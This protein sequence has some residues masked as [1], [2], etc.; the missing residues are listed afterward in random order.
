M[1]KLLQ[2]LIALSLLTCWLQVGCDGKTATK[3]EERPNVLL[4]TID[5]LRADRLPLYGYEK[6]KTPHL[7]ALASQGVVFDKA[8]AHTPITLPS[9]TSILTG[10]YPPQHGVR[11]N[12]GFYVHENLTTMAEILKTSRYQTAAFVSAFVLDSRFGLDQGFDLYDDDLVDGRRRFS[13]FGVKDRRAE[14]TVS[15]VI[16]WLDKKKDVKSPFFVW[17]HLY[18]PHFKY[19]P[20]EPFLSRFKDPYDGEIAYTD[21]EIGRL[22]DNLKK[23]GLYDNTLVI[24]T[25]D[26]GESFGEHGE[27]THS[28]FVYEATQW[29]PM[30]IKFPYSAHGGRRIKGLVR[31]I[32]ILPTALETLGVNNISKEVQGSLPGISLLSCS[33]RG[34]ASPVSESYAEAYLPYTQFGWSPIYAWR[35]NDIKYIEA[36]T[37]ELYDLGKDTRE[38]NNIYKQRLDDA[39]AYRKK[40]DKFRAELVPVVGEDTSKKTMDEETVA[41]LKALGYMGDGVPKKS[42]Q[43]KDPKD[44]VQLHEAREEAHHLMEEEKYDAAVPM[45]LKILKDDPSNHSIHNDLASVYAE[46]ERWKDAERAYLKTVELAP[47]KAGSHRGLAKVYFKGLKNFEP[48]KREI[49]AARALE[50]KDPSLWTLEGNLLHAQG[51]MKEATV[52][53]G[54]AHQAGV[55]DASMYA[56]YSSAL[57][58]LGQFEEAREMVER[59]LRIDNQNP[60]AHYNRGVIMEKLEAFNEAEKAYQKAILFNSRNI[61]AYENLGGMLERLGRDEHAA[62]VYSKALRIKPDSARVLYLLGSL[63]LKKGNVDAA[64]SLL[65]KS[66][67]LKP[68][69]AGSR[70]NYGHALEQKNELDKAY[71]QYKALTEIYPENKMGYADAWLRMARLRAEQGKKEEATRHLRKALLAGGESVAKVAR[72]NALLKELISSAQDAKQN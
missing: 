31:H 34:A 8:A 68:S 32:D 57:T 17:T 64:L 2:G 6:G 5:T 22:L 16:D 12:G 42:E 19:E 20:P 1:N 55:Q 37:A 69:S 15:R 36:P 46:L 45:L 3:S 39:L 50:P 53:Y 25:A 63:H 11:S 41:K 44:M 21:R 30:I 23:L 54:R 59:S 10:L 71:L 33:A 52:A 7:D 18:D 70:T 48:A 13:K 26:H 24:V 60:V 14:N 40:L 67:T 65:Q 49:E 51:K 9:H 4:I 56:G 58:N 38:Q 61:L 47:G 62:T 66:V 28:L 27:Q 29:V 43:G 35:D 72:A